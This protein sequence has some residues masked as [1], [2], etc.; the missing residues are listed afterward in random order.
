MASSRYERDINPLC[1]IINSDLRPQSLHKVRDKMVGNRNPRTSSVSSGVKS[2]DIS[3]LLL[4]RM[5][6]T[7]TSSNLLNYLCIVY[8]I[9][10]LSCL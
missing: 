2:M 1:R 8:D 10:F 4:T 7:N 5:E 9:L 6:D 3:P